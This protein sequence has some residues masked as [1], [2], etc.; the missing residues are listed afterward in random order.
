MQC[1]LK[2]GDMITEV[3]AHRIGAYVS[4]YIT[5]WLLHRL[6]RQGSGAPGAQDRGGRPVGGASD[7]Q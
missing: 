7:G 3:Y 5:P 6:A 2:P 1:G 4:D